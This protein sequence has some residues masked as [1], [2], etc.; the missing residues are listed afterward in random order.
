[1]ELKVEI[2]GL[3]RIGNTTDRVLKGIERE[4]K[5]GLY[6]AAKKVEADAKRSI[7]S[8]EKTGRT[9]RRRSVTHQ[10]SAPGEAPASD[11]GRLVNSI[12]GE[13]VGT[14]EA[15]VRAGG[16]IVKYARMLEFGT[17]KMAARPF[18]QPALEKNRNWIVERLNKAVRT[19]AINASKK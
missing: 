18:F 6:A 14:F 4:L 15:I 12:N 9:Y 10:A 17:I 1:M 11:T 7:A 16:G 5:V 3:D 13:V 2:E 8:G 19:A